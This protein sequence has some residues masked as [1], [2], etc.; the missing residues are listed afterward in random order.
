MA[1]TITCLYKNISELN[2]FID[3]NEL[4]QYPNLLV[5]VF[6]GTPESLFIAKLQKEMSD[7]LPLA[8]IAGCSTS[9]E[10]HEGR[11]TEKQTIICFTIFEKTEIKSF[12]LNRSDFKDSYEMGK[13]LARELA[14]FNTEA[15]IIFPAGFDVDSTDLLEGINETQP[16][17]VISGGLAGDNGLFQ[18][19]FSF[20]QD[21]ITSD[22]LVAVALQSGHLSV[23]HFENYQWQ[24]IGKSFTVTKA[25]GSIIYSLDDKRPLTILKRYLGDA[26]LRN[27]RNQVLNSRSFYSTAEKKYLFLL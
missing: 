20:T 6:T 16:N 14:I 27:C 22:G 25:E 13:A 5:Q 3:L 26:L 1:Q 23:R 4:T 21:G 24:E 17:M 11:I 18:E 19:G 8:H 10:I 12:L 7:K 15:V 9:G 2:S